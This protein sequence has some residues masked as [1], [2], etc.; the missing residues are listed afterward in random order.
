VS[1][2]VDKDKSVLV[3]KAAASEGTVSTGRRDAVTKLAY[4]SPVI[5]GLLFS[6]RAAAQFTPP[7]PP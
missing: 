1:N 2:S 4:A 5:A 3:E 7:A 6:Q